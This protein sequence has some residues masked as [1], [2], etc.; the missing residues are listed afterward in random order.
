MGFG[1]TL[2]LIVH[3]AICLL[4]I[5]LVTLQNDKGGGLAGAFG[6]T[7]GAAFTG[8]SAVTILTKITQGL[9]LVSFI[10][11]LGLS[12]FSSQVSQSNFGES[13]L[14]K[15]SNALSGAL[16]QQAP[17]PLPGVGGQAAPAPAP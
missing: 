17:M 13:E 11:L 1:F 16:P 4:M 3:I 8:G 15:N 10:V 14:K 9:A 7:G 6:G 2:L 5:L 12:Y